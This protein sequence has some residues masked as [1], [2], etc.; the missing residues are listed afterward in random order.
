MSY[1]GVLIQN[2]I[3]NRLNQVQNL[4]FGSKCNKSI[5]ETDSNHDSPFTA[6]YQ[7]TFFS[8][9]NKIRGANTECVLKVH[10]GVS[11]V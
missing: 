9:T 4:T 3:F 6:N 7:R 10:Y 11:V 1:G 8:K 2:D 5:G